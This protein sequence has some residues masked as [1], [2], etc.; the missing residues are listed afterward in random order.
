MNEINLIRAYSRKPHPTHERNGKLEAQ[1]D[2]VCL[3]QKVLGEHP[4]GYSRPDQ[5]FD[6]LYIAKAQIKNL[7]NKL[8]LCRMVGKIVCDFS[9]LEIALDALAKFKETYDTH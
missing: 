6:Y 3:G 1:F 2:E 9:E 7:A 8:K 4:A 5:K